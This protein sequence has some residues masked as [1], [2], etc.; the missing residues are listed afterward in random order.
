[1]RIGWARRARGLSQQQLA[2]ACGIALRT[3]QGWESGSYLPTA[4]ALVRLADALG[5]SCD[6][7]LG[8]SG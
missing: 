6:Y 1:M 5:S 7:L 2:Q 4:P 8:R 3:L